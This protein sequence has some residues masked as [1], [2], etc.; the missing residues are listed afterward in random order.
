MLYI[1]PTAWM[2]STNK[3]KRPEKQINRGDF[4]VF[5]TDACFAG[6]YFA[7]SSCSHIYNFAWFDHK[8][9]LLCKNLTRI[10]VIST[11]RTIPADEIVIN[12][13]DFVP[14]STD[15]IVSVARSQVIF[16]LQV[17]CNC[18]WKIQMPD[19]QVTKWPL[20]GVPMQMTKTFNDNLLVLVKKTDGTVFME[21]Y[22]PRGMNLIRKVLFP[23]R[24]F[25]APT[26]DV[27]QL[28]NGDFVVSWIDTEQEN[29]TKI[30][31][32]ND[33]WNIV[34][35]SDF[36]HKSVLTHKYIAVDQMENLFIAELLTES[37]YVLDSQFT[38]APRLLFTNARMPTGRQ[39]FQPSPILYV[40]ETEQFIMLQNRTQIY[41]IGML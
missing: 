15:K 37:I 2:I 16:I 36:R 14:S 32:F 20:D 5:I 23:T 19:K 27:I 7:P 38:Q 25:G 33:N 35:T 6:E 18:I 39:M 31:Q 24:K 28:S 21:L 22:N 10:I 26:G 13:K 34:R 41:I 9:Y 40:T 8:L 30:S 11:N 3:P 4:I 17:K 12:N 1:F 29:V